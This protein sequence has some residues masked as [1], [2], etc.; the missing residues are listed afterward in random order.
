[1]TNKYLSFITDEDLFEC[2][3]FLYTEYE[4]ALEGIDFDKFFKNRIDTFKMTFDMGINNLSEQDWLAAEL[5]RQVEKTI[6]NHVGTF[7]EKLIGKIEGYTNYPVGYDYDVAKDDNTL[8]AEIKNKHNTLTGTHTKSLFQKICG[9]AEKYPDAICYYVRI[10]DTKSRN[11]IWEFRSGSID[12]NTREKPRFS[13]PRVRIASG[14]QFYKIVT[15]EEDVFKQLAYNIP[16]ALDDWIETKRAKKGSSL[17]LFAEL[18]QQAKANNRTLSE[19]IISI[20]YPK[21]NYISF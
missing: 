14:D 19:E 1:M 9:Y 16:I 12:E 3:E 20:N 10:I 21:S 4:K 8:F 7:H 6:T 11:D 2:I 13:H 18:Y 17:G 5:Q 15:G